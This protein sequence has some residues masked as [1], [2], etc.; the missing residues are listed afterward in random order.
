M[1]LKSLKI[2][3][4][5][6]FNFRNYEKITFNFGEKIN[7]ILG[8]NGVGKTNILEA[9]YLIS[10]LRSFRITNE[11]ELI[12]NDKDFFKIELFIDNQKL[13][14]VIN[15]DQKSY[16]INQTKTKVIDFLGNF[17]CLLYE[18]SELNLFSLGP[19]KEEILST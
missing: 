3:K 17:N 7:I 19:K 16:F 6:L 5:N 4:I 11:L 14:M 1:N 2:T 9:I 10:N 18:P 13:S 12:K 8:K 15:R